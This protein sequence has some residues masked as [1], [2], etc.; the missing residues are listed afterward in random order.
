M[1]AILGNGVYSYKEAA[2][3]TG[4]KPT[5][6]YEWFRGRPTK[7][8][9]PAV[10][11][12]DYAPVEGNYAISFLDLI[13]VLVAGHLR[14]HGVKLQVVCKAY[15][16]LQRDLGTTH[17]FCHKKLAT[18]GTVVLIES[19]DGAGSKEFAD[20]LTGQGIFKSII[21]PFLK[22]IDYDNLKLL[23]SRWRIRKGVVIDPGRCFGAPIVAAAGVPTG[24]LANSYEANSRNAEQVAEFYNVDPDDVFVAVNFER[25]LA[26]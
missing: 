15:K 26:A 19:V 12:G 16:R 17:P 18:D 9:R 4:L 3:L 21:E 14:N 8:G 22:T 11:A 5:R 20:V 10:F 1:V 25:S 2:R 7:P 13:D 23:A 24:I 6:V